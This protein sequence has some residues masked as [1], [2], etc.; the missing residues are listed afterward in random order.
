MYQDEYLFLPEAKLVDKLLSVFNIQSQQQ[1]DPNRIIS[2]LGLLNLLNIVSIAQEGNT[3]NKLSNLISDTSSS[4]NNQSINPQQI[5]QLIQ[6]LNNNSS[7][8]NKNSNPLNTL[9]NQKDQSNLGLDN[10]LGMLNSNDNNKLD[11]TLILKL[12]NFI[13]QIKDNKKIN[14]ES[15][16]N[17]TN[18]PIKSE[19]YEYEEDSKE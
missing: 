13:N 11:P 19:T 6:K 2:I 14:R 10:L 17:E 1:L 16:Q 15:S 3:S 12:M 9:L 7:N 5:Q 4:T 8:Q 18:P